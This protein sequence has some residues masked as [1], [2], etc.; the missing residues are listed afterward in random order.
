MRGRPGR[1]GT[2]DTPKAAPSSPDLSPA[3]LMIRTFQLLIRRCVGGYSRCTCSTSSHIHGSTMQRCG[4]LGSG[5]KSP[6]APVWPSAAHRRGMVTRLP[7]HR[8]SDPSSC[9]ECQTR[10]LHSVLL[11]VMTKAAHAVAYARVLKLFKYKV[12]FP[13]CSLVEGD[14]NGI[15]NKTAPNMLADGFPPGYPCS[16]LLDT[17]LPRCEVTGLWSRCTLAL[18]GA[19]TQLDNVAVAQGRPP[20]QVWV[21]GAPHPP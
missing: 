9:S 18:S 7:C 1:P 15:R 4:I 10:D 6:C 16:F 20:R 8:G 19:V 17:W 2:G 13:A 11:S 14:F 3:V 21:P 5:Q 12:I